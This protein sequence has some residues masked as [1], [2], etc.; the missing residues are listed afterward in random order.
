MYGWSEAEALA[1]N[2]DDRIPAKLRAA[3]LAQI[4]QL[5]LANILEPSSTQRLCKDGTVIT[6][7]LTSTALMD[8]TGQMYAIATTERLQQATM[9]SLQGE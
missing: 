6:V 8:E 4:K 5:S 3:A 7:W 2:V 9:P 1:M